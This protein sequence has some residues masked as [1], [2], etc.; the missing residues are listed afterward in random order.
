MKI[1]NIISLFFLISLIEEI[2]N[3]KFPLTKNINIPKNIRILNENQNLI[4]TLYYSDKENYYYLKLYLGDEKIPQTYI[5]DTT[6]SLISSPCNL[7]DSCEVHN[8]PPFKINKEADIINCNSQQCSTVIKQSDCQEEKCYFNIENIN[9][10]N[11]E[12]FLV[13]S[14]IFLNNSDSLPLFTVPIGCTIKEGYYYKIKEANGVIGLNN[15]DNTFI[16]NIFNLNIISNNLFTICLSKDGGYLSFGQIIN[17]LNYDNINYINLLASSNHL[18]ELQI[19]YIKIEEEVISEK[20]KSY[21]DTTNKYSIFPATMY[22]SL[23]EYFTKK[24]N[25]FNYDY[26]YGYCKELY[27]V[28]EENILYSIFHNIVVSFEGYNYEWKTQNYI[29]KYKIEQNQIKACLG[30]KSSDTNN[31][32]I[33]LGTNFMIGHDII[34]DK[35]NQR[36]ALLESDCDKYKNRDNK[37][38]DE[39][40][41]SEQQENNIQENSDT[42]KENNENQNNTEYNNNL[43]GEIR[44]D[45]NFNNNSIINE[46]ELNENDRTDDYSID[47]KEQNNNNYSNTDIIE[48]NNNNIE[49]E[50]KNSL[51]NTKQEYNETVSDNT[52]SNNIDSTSEYLI[53]DN[54]STYVNHDINDNLN[55]TYINNITKEILDSQINDIL[56]Y[57][58]ND[59]ITYS[60]ANNDT[61]N[62]SIND[63]INHTLTD[64]INDTNYDNINDTIDDT[65]DD[66]INDTI[67]DIVNDTNY[68]ISDII[69][70][71]IYTINDTI[72]DISDVM[73]DTINFTI[74]DIINDTLNYS[75]NYIINN[76]IN[77]IINDT[78]NDT[79]N[80]ILIDNISDIL[81]DTS[82]DTINDTMELYSGNTIYNIDNSS[83]IINDD[84]YITEKIEETI[85]RHIYS[86]TIIISTNV[87]QE[88]K[89]SQINNITNEKKNNEN[90]TN[91]INEYQTNGNNSNNIDKNE[92]LEN[93]DKS[94]VN[95]LFKTFKSFFKNKLLYFLFA[96]LG[97]ILCFV[98]V[99]LI[100]CAIIS[101][102]KMFKRRNYIE[103]VDDTQKNSRYNTA[104]IS[105]KS[106]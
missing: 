54:I 66:T 67:N 89:E 65:I 15:N 101:C 21:I 36:I 62:D 76:T 13:N 4:S 23:I 61:I 96:L 7:C 91:L 25:I 72:Y 55:S 45:N 30:F 95:G 9:N 103:Q 48:D 60:I 104:S 8:N 70:D 105:S 87:N 6:L 32:I 26:P 44:M 59:N 102:I 98:I 79:V 11:I 82:H 77:D 39:L 90:N 99:I 93:E 50:I 5:L 71:T 37:E 22:N 74:N 18:F 57:E 88:K 78:I 12:G 100:S 81:N 17:F 85:I 46:T 106:S 92:L 86:S 94:I 41:L 51:I 3:K 97:V 68:G 75:I 19:N 53:N 47:F 14:K 10:K 52:M 64:I 28:E 2:A 83:T 1:I 69:N 38:S 16:D 84:N 20:Y 29:I 43:T 80:D 40:S 42:K 73:N 56:S 49:Q 35:T 33:I 34:F 63:T 27:N 58:L 24:V 31:D